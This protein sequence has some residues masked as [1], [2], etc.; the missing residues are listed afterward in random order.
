[1]IVKMVG[2]GKMGYNLAL[3]MMD[4]NFKVVGFD[5]NPIAR[6]KAMN[7]NISCVSNL[8]D[9]VD[10]N[11]R[12]VVW[13]ML[14]SGNI[15][16]TAL[17]ELI[18][19]CNPG[20]IIIDGGNSDPRNS[21]EMNKFM[22]KK[23]LCFFDIGTSGGVHGARHGASFMCG[24]DSQVFKEIEPLVNA[25]SIPGGCIYTGETGSG[26]YL[27]M[28]HNAMLYGM[29]QTI[30]EGFELLSKSE[31]SYNLEQVA[32]SLSKSS[33][34]R[35]WLLELV[36]NAF[37]KDP[38]LSDIPGIVGASKTTVWTLESACDLGVPIPVI[39]LS[40]MMRQRSKQEESF[41]SKIIAA[42]RNE[43]GGHKETS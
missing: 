40:L 34:I 31:F 14:P 42:L 32:D 33:V 10:S 20:D 39:A 26:H 28:V 38:T 17:Y 22:K 1:M 27:K 4:N 12:N 13:V 24:G 25:L 15:T 16:N 41:S 3:N 6:A 36:A 30:G 35:G 37:R 43:V 21:V 19:L 23:K 9:L 7:S 8:A 5:V 29:M 11:A 2:L 18:D